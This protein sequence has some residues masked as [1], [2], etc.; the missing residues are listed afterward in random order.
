MRPKILTVAMRPGIPPSLA[1]GRSDLRAALMR[2]ARAG[3]TA[4][5]FA[6]ATGLLEVAVLLVRR[7]L[8]GTFI[9]APEDFVWL[10]PLSYLMHFRWPALAAVA[11]VMLW[12]RAPLHRVAVLPFAT[13]GAFSLLLQT[14]SRLHLWAVGLLALGI[15]LQIARWAGAR[16]AGWRRLV[17]R[18]APALAALTLGLAAALPA[19]RWWRERRAYATLPAAR[20]GA[21]NLL[22]IILDTVRAANLGLYGYGRATSPH[23]E[24]W[25]GQG[26]TFERAFA[27]SPWTL[28]THATLFTGRYPH[29]LSTD[30]RTGLDRRD[31]TLA[32]ALASVGY[33]T[34]GFS[35]NQGYV[36]SETGL[37]RGFVRFDDD[38][39]T[40]EQLGL[41]SLLG[42][43]LA[44]DFRRLPWRRYDRKWA[45][46][47]NAEFLGWL[48]R[49]PADRPFF[50]FLNYY[51]AHTPYPADRRFLD[52]V[53]GDATKVVDR[54][55]AGIARVDHHLG[56]LLDSLDRRGFLD[57][58]IVVVTADHGELLGEHGL[59]KHG[60]ALY[61]PLLH[62]PLVVIG[63]GR[64]PA[65]VRVAEPVSL[66]D[67]P[68]TILELAGGAA[69]AALPGRSLARY[70]AGHA[71]LGAYSSSPVLSMVH[72][73]IRTPPEEPVT[74][75]DMWSLVLGDWHYILNGDGGEE[76]YHLAVDPAEARNLAREPASRPVLD[77]CR[78]R[79][80]AARQSGAAGLAGTP[81]SPGRP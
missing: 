79:L 16:P 23:L 67:V 7:H 17:V 5:W 29:E 1:V 41:A 50:G 81:L 40:R 51:D 63:R 18:T 39:L 62:V 31:L 34:G 26:V 54:Y 21:P 64:I 56:R 24:R 12:P 69:G 3:L 61:R 46:D 38:R 13:L 44:R 4:L 75:G 8:L 45:E 78:R 20:P 42:Q 74:R 71:E 2:G 77:L 37:D 19:A 11:V 14:G 76:L 43:F 9:Y 68:A 49:S 30:W 36:S 57:N 32:E 70:W 65:G 35:A 15:G 48:D 25:A 53:G 28:P 72:R 66:R 33:R 58:T 59:V 73:G 55:D 6:L 27:T 80:A 10:T 22:L 60:N 47:V 52:Q